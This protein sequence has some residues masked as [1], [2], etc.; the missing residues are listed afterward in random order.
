MS[1]LLRGL[2]A[3]AAAQG[4]LRHRTAPTLSSSAAPS[5]P[6]S[7]IEDMIWEVDEDCDQRVNWEE[8][9]AM[10]ERCRDDKTGTQG[11]PWCPGACG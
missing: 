1:R 6:Q 7:E 11:Q 4:V 10:Y 3:L 8:F 2:A 9:Q 5:L